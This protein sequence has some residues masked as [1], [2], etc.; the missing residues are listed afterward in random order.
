MVANKE[1][2]QA[3][4]AMCKKI[5]ISKLNFY[6]GRHGEGDDDDDDDNDVAPAA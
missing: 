1:E 2:E 3:L 6:Q 5:S 4:M